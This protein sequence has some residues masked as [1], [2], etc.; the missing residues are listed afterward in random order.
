MFVATV[1]AFFTSRLTQSIPC[2]DTAPLPLLLPQGVSVPSV[3]ISG[4][5]PE[6]CR[7]LAREGEERQAGRQVGQAGQALPRAGGRSGAAPS[8]DVCP[9]CS[10]AFCRIKSESL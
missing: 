9:V 4:G 8:S 10:F 6:P 5:R 7:G 2:C 1:S 3:P